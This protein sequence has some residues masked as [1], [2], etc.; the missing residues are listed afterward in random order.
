MLYDIV[1]VG[2]G[3][4]GLTAAIYARRAEKSV[5]VL[6]AAAFGGQ[7]SYTDN[8]ENYPGISSV[9]GADFA[10]AL[11]AQAKSCG[12]D[13]KIESVSAVKDGKIKTVISSKGEYSCKS[14][15]I[16]SGQKSR[17]LGADGEQRYIGSGVSFCAVCDGNF[18]RN[19]DV[20]VV[21][22]GNTALRDALYLSSICKTVYLVHRR[23]EFRGE[24]LL[25]SQLEKKPNVVFKLNSTVQRIDGA[26]SVKSVLLDN[27]SG[28][29]E[30]LSVSGVFVAVGQMPHNEPFSDVLKL[31]AAGYA[32]S[33]EDCRTERSGIFVAGDCRAKPLRQL[34][35]AV[36]DGAVAATQ[37]CEYIDEQ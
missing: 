23:A 16:A 30:Q 29:G 8:I 28:E 9:S 4:A 5:L 31:D 25:V 17:H 10:D 12:A 2:G 32:K 15:I 14:V 34:A 36:S 6:E 20:C 27:G 7:I 21:G 19:R 3:P 22:G 24:K 35:T 11:Y 33:G 18:F 37:A 1:I 26:E 13:M